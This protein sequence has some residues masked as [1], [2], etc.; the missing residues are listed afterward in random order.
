MKNNRLFYLLFAVLFIWLLILSINS[1]SNRNLTEVNEIKE[2]NVSGF[3]T[4]LSK[5][6]DQN[7]SSIVSVEQNDNISTGFIYAKKDNLVYIVTSYHGVS[8]GSGL[9]VYFNNGVRAKANVYKYDIFNDLALVECDFDYD[10]KPIVLGNSSLIKTGEFVLGIGSAG[11]IEYGFSSQFGMISNSYREILNHIT[12][13][14]NRHDYYLGLIQLSGEFAQ[15]YSGSPLFNM[16]GEVVGMIN[17][18]DDEVVLAL[19]INEIKVVVEKMLNDED[20]QKVQLGIKGRFVADLEKYESTSLNIGVEIVKGYFVEETLN[21]SLAYKLGINKGDVILSINGVEINNVDDMRKAE[22][23]LLDEY[24]IIINR[25]GE[26]IT[27]KGN[28]ND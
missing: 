21:N 24:E 18:K 27:F 12:Y 14:G 8:S 26:E 2:Y 16:N 13:E 4:D 9:S 23:S 3:S 28:L 15:G 19:P 11:S 20:Y 6:Y 25:N 1:F 5:V 17:M 22:Y 7:K 10:V